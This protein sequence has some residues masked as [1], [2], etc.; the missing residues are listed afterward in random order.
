MATRSEPFALIGGVE[1]VEI[2]ASSADS[3]MNIRR[4]S[5][6]RECLFGVL[7]RDCCSVRCPQRSRGLEA[8]RTKSAEDSGRYNRTRPFLLTKLC[9]IP[10]F[11]P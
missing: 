11:S 7:R 5:N 4:A 10:P 8:F 6:W 3:E 1:G 9:L 2:R